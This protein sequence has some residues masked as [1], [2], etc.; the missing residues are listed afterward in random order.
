MTQTQFED[1]LLSEL[2]QLVA[3]RPVPPVTPPAER[4]ARAGRA[5][6][7]PTRLVIGSVT[8]TA[9]AAGAVL[10]ATWSWGGDVTPAFAV[11]RQPDG[12]VTVKINRLSDAQGLESKLRAAGVPAVVH[13]TAT[14]GKIC[15]APGKPAAARPT[16]PV[17]ASG[18]ISAAPGH[19]ASFSITRDMVRSG[20]TLLMT[21]SG[22]KPGPQ[23]IGMAVVNGPVSSCTLKDGPAPGPGE[24]FSTAGSVGRGSG[25]S[26][27]A[28]SQSLHVG[29]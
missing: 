28:D 14:P 24:Q 7:R 9:V 17:H 5:R 21:V 22:D 20:Q 29:P 6:R 19:P 13:Y 2:R 10:A 16:G 3:E 11:D 25:V 1:R 27:G 18:S 15:R 4:A 8:A 12:T 23:T 26:S